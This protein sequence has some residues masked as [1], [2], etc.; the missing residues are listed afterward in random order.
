MKQSTFLLA[1]S[2]LFVVIACVSPSRS[3][4]S[5]EGLKVID[6][7]AAM[8]NLQDKLKLS[9]LGQAVHYI[10]LETNDSCLIAGNPGVG[11][12]DSCFVVS[13][14]Y[15]L[16]PLTYSFERQSGRF[17]AQVGHFGEDPTGYTSPVWFYN[18]QEGLFYFVRNPNQLQKYDRY[19]RYQGRMFVPVQPEYPVSFVF[20]DS[21]VL[22]YYK[23]STDR[24]V[25]HSKILSVFNENGI[26]VDSVLRTSLRTMHPPK[27]ECKSVAIFSLFGSDIR[28]SV[29][30][31]NTVDIDYS[32]SHAS[33]LWKCGEKIRLKDGLNDTI[34]TWLAGKG[35]RPSFAFRLGRWRLDEKAW[36]QCESRDKLLVLGV[37]ETGNKLYFRCLS[38]P[39]ETLRE[40]SER[41]LLRG[42]NAFELLFSKIYHGVYDK[43]IGTT[44]MAPLDKGIWDD[45]NGFLPFEVSSNTQGE[46]VGILQAH[47]VVSCMEEH[48]EVKNNPKFAPLLKVK[49]E[50][51]PVVV[52]VSDK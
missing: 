1:A 13:T 31:D 32:S 18:E 26:E 6:L 49:E 29:N 15:G 3:F 40:A 19:G 27:G 36:Q 25:S 10:P 23:A 28:V 14:H 37:C 16:V 2:F 52:I 21:L 38:Q 5:S 45:L 41:L 44:C 33:A 24:T 30:K 50:D 22:S 7:E 17:I 51:N 4:A 42:G 9:D 39:F 48:P 35:L 43:Q 8:G 46:F 20:M 34:Y 47:E 11:L 12:T